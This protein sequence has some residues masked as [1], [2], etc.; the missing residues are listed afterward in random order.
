MIFNSFAYFFFFSF[1]FLCESWILAMK[2]A[3]YPLIFFSIEKIASIRVKYRIREGGGGKM[4]RQNWSLSRDNFSVFPWERAEI[5]GRKNDRAKEGWGGEQKALKFSITLTRF[6]SPTTPVSR[7][8]GKGLVKRTAIGLA[9]SPQPARFTSSRVRVSVP[10]SFARRTN[11][12]SE[13]AI[14]HGLSFAKCS[15]VWTAL[16]TLR[17]QR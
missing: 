5:A 9:T 17:F 12:L 2:Q 1:P 10:S 6:R 11:P 15:Y 4:E 3:L 16:R 8:L 7:H 14:K 13:A